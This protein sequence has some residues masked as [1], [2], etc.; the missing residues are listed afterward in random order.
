VFF[1]DKILHI[2]VLYIKTALKFKNELRIIIG[3]FT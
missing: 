2:N 3:G 1:Y